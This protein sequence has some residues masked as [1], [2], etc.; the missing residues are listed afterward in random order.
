V[1][2]DQGRP[3][4]NTLV[5][6]QSTVASVSD[7]VT[8]QPTSYSATTDSQGVFSVT[9]PAVGFYS[10]CVGAAGQQLLNNCEWN[11]AQS[12]VQVTA[13]SATALTVITLQTG[14]PVSIRLDD[15]NALL[16]KLGTSGNAWVRFAVSESNGHSH[17][18]A[19]VSADNKG[20]N[21]QVLVPIGA[22][23]LTFS[24]QAYNV[25]IVNQNNAVVNPLSATVS[26]VQTVLSN[27][28]QVL[29]YQ[30]AAP[31]GN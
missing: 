31:T 21:Y 23:S 13:S 24:V 2:S 8:V 12:V 20:F 17:W 28:S 30:V 22:S 18:A 25:N 29:Y 5:N 16:P 27:L 10:V 3:V 19:A 6:V 7:G 14:I 1:I 11:L 9:L 26:A 4:S 15:P